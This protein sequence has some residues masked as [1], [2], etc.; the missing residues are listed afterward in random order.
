MLNPEPDVP[1]TETFA[2][3]FS[4][5]YDYPVHFT[6]DLFDPCNPCLRQV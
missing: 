2:Q 6:R 3:T 5:R 1:R 4:I